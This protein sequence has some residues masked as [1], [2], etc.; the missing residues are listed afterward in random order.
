[1]QQKCIQRRCTTTP[2]IVILYK[3]RQ[4]NSDLKILYKVGYSRNELPLCCGNRSWTVECER[5]I[6]KCPLFIIDSLAR[7]LI[8]QMLSTTVQ[9]TYS[10][11]LCHTNI[12]FNLSPNNFN[13]L[14][15]LYTKVNYPRIL[16][17]CII[18]ISHYLLQFNFE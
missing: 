16:N 2:N 8:R 6:Y 10:T 7:A 5:Q 3:V 14:I 17:H 11:S 13:V 1:M 4:T 15:K 18:H 9:T 12:L